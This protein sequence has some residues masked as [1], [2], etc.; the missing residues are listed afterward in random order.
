[1]NPNDG[2]NCPICGPTVR[3]I[4]FVLPGHQPAST[5]A[6][7][8]RRF[9]RKKPIVVEAQLFDPIHFALPFR[10]KFVCCLDSD[11]WYIQTLESQRFDLTPGCWIIKGVR[12][13]FYA[14]EA[15]ILEAT[16]DE[17]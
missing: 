9:I 15:D 6:S 4:D 5:P 14:I 13:E 11:G 12:G 10:E 7:A 8:P 2:L 1:M 16:Y 17:V 3:C